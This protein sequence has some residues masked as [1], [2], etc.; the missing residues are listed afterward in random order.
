MRRSGVSSSS[1]GAPSL[2]RTNLKRG[3]SKSTDKVTQMVGTWERTGTNDEQELIFQLLEDAV[4]LKRQFSWDPIS[5]VWDGPSPA[6]TRA[7]LTPILRRWISE[8]QFYRAQMLVQPH[9]VTFN[10]PNQGHDLKLCAA[11]VYEHWMGEVSYSG[12]GI[13]AGLLAQK[14]RNNPHLIA[15]PPSAPKASLHSAKEFFEQK[16]FFWKGRT[17]TR[18]DAITFLANTLGGVHLDLDKAKKFEHIL[19]LKNYLGF[20]VTGKNIQMLTGLQVEEARQDFL[21]RE[22]VYD[23]MELLCLDTAKIFFEAVASSKEAFDSF[24]RSRLT[25]LPLPTPPASDCD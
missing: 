21:R 14:Y 20:E 17:Y 15:R 16:M 2:W 25:Q 4:T 22:R 11:G 3:C 19:A 10:I 6:I 8:G 5:Q 12:I 24:I 9:K 13:S 23:S 18:R 1:N 7:S